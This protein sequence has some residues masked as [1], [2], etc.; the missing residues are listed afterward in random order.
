M[1]WEAQLGAGPPPPTGEVPAPPTPSPPA[2]VQL[3]EPDC[4]KRKP[5]SQTIW[6]SIGRTGSLSAASSGLGAEAPQETGVRGQA[7]QRSG[8]GI[9]THFFPAEGSGSL[10]LRFFVLI[11][12]S[13]H[14]LTQSLVLRVRGK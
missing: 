1:G 9:W 4:L 3:M 6:S 13:D 5:T 12:R 8:K 7:V 2:R 14:P 11:P 10:P